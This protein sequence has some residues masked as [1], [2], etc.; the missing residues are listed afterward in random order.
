MNWVQPKACPVIVDEQPVSL[1]CRPYHKLSTKFCAVGHK[2]MLARGLADTPLFCRINVVTP[3]KFAPLLGQWYSPDFNPPVCICKLGLQDEPILKSGVMV[4][5]LAPIFG[6][7][8][9]FLCGQSPMAQ[10]WW[11][12]YSQRHQWNKQAAAKYFLGWWHSVRGCLGWLRCAE[13]KKWPRESVANNTKQAVYL[14][15]GPNK[16]KQ[17]RNPPSCYHRCPPPLWRRPRRLRKP[18]TGKEQWREWKWWKKVGYK[19]M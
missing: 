11:W 17:P 19:C 13:G 10:F 8:H 3:R 7:G 6:T 4:P 18:K 9:W 1:A 16:T 2:E 12:D 14:W 15:N 5:V